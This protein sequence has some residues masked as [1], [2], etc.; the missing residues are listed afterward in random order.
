MSPLSRRR[1]LALV[2][3]LTLAACGDKPKTDAPGTAPAAAPAAPAATPAAAD[4]ATATFAP[5]L[6]I[7][8]SKLTRTAN[9]LYYQDLVVGK[10]ARADSGATVSVH[11]TGYLAD[12]TM[13]ETSTK[14]TPI[15]F[16]LGQGRVVQGWDQGIPGMKVGGKRQL[17]IPPAL[18]YGDM[19]QGPIPA[20]AI[21]IFTVELMGV[22][23]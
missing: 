6:A 2:A 17:V 3:T 1:A 10:G 11:Y 13:F 5:A 9:G 15:E 18:G 21:M 23:K 7:D 16:T 12:G 8:V 22:K 19:G 4:P 14:G 20:G